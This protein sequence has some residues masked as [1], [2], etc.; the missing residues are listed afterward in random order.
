MASVCSSLRGRYSVGGLRFDSYYGLVAV[1]IP[2]EG[3]VS[4]AVV[5]L[6]VLIGSRSASDAYLG[7]WYSFRG[8]VDFPYEFVLHVADGEDFLFSLDDALFLDLVREIV[9]GH[10]AESLGLESH[11]QVF[12]YEDYLAFGVIVPQPYCGGYD[13]VVRNVVNERVPDLAGV[14]MPHLDFDVTASFP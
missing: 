1:V 11:V 6:V 3:K 7:K 9:L 4:G 10:E 8:F 2:G 13:P 12:G 5:D 14:A